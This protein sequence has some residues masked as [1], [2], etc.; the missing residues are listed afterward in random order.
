M[1]TLII[2]DEDQAISALKSEIETHCKQLQLIGVATSVKE[3][4]QKIKTLQPELIFLDIQL[5][6]GL[7]FEIL[8]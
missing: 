1:K 3:G 6:D 2:E 8:S 7:G 5:S 4:I